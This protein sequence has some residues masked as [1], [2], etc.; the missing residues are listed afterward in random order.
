MN[1]RIREVSFELLRPGQIIE[2]KKRCSLVFIPVGGLEY[3]GPHLPL[4]VDAI[5]ATIVAREVCKA[6][7][8]GLVIP[9]L[10]WSTE[11]ERPPRMAEGL[12]FKPDD[13]IVGMDFPS[14]QWKSHYYQEHVFALVLASK[15][16]MFINHGY[17]VI[18][19]VNGHGAVNH[20][21]TIERLSKHYSHVSNCTVEWGLALPD[22]ITEKNLVGHADIYE[23]SLMMYYQTLL[24]E[25]ELVDM[26]TLPVKGKQIKYQDYSIV[27]GLG[28]G[29][30]PDPE[31]IVRTDPRNASKEL[32]EK[33][34][35]D[36][37]KKFIGMTN[38]VLQEKGL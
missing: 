17:K 13:W 11:R 21:E 28:F 33:I 29:S 27:D 14:A 10:Y 22:E 5:N 23:V 35:K 12:G 38:K 37:V 30:T 24:G 15:I 7:N 34:F 31:Q 32:G 1:D 6:I 9:T 16:E 20:M 8:K 18:M 19:I 25:D 26:R 2:E 3:H 4:G 36:I